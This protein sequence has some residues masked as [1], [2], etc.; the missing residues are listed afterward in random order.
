VQDEE[1]AINEDFQQTALQLADALDL[2][3]IESARIVLEALG[4][5]E[6]L[7]RPLLESSI[8]RFHQT[9][10]YLL[11]S[12]R[13]IL[14]A[15][16]DV[17]I[18]EPIKDVL[19]GVIIRVLQPQDSSGAGQSFVSKCLQKMGE[20]KSM[21]QSLTDRLNGASVLGQIQRSEFHETI[22]YQ[23]ASLVQQHE[24]LGI[25]VHYLVKA[26]HAEPKDFEQILDIL[27][28]ADKYDNLLGEFR[29]CAIG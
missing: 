28:R 9:R 7:G 26:N 21:L 20:M 25:I 16:I 27:K 11:D 24:S 12:F 29:F 19:L 18:P 13:L 15:S 3:E 2:D 8:I 23:R 17:N 1:Y 6:I 5:A 4:D 10:K 14:Y 22:E